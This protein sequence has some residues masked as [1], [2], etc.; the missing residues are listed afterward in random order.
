MNPAHYEP[1]EYSL[2]RIVFHDNA[3]SVSYEFSVDGQQRILSYDLSDLNLV[4]A[5]VRAAAG[6]PPL[7]SMIARPTDVRLRTVDGEFPLH[8]GAVSVPVTTDSR[9]FW[10]LGQNFLN[11][12]TTAPQVHLDMVAALLPENTK[13]R[14]KHGAD[15]SASKLNPFSWVP[16]I[17]DW[18]SDDCLSP[19]NSTECTEQDETGKVNTVTFTCDCGIPICTNMTMTV[20][21]PVMIFD[22]STGTFHAGTETKTYTVCVCTCMSLGSAGG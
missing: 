10:L 2:Q 8:K 17:F 22:S 4:K 1:R 20:D 5:D 11:N 15:S 7:L 14:L 6:Q 12:S 18:F 3:P 16:N 13:L 9:S 19:D 21:V